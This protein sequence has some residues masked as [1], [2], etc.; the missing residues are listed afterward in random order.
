MILDRIRNYHC[1]TSKYQRGL[2]LMLTNKIKKKANLYTYHHNAI[3]NPKEK[4]MKIAQYL[5]G[6]CYPTLKEEII[7]Q[8]I[9]NNAPI[10]IL[11]LLDLLEDDQEYNN[12]FEII[13]ST[14][15]LKWY[16]S[17]F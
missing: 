7:K 4:E 6:L 2:K 14:N 8:C 17:E 3:N 5:A 1:I 10:E 16:C 9:K 15:E 12:K 11:N 13:R